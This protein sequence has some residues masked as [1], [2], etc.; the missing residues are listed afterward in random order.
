MELGAEHQDARKLQ[1]SDLE[2]SIYRKERRNGECFALPH[3]EHRG[4]TTRQ[5]EN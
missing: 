5:A 4:L 2:L 1:P 3:E